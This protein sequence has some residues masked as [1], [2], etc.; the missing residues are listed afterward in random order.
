MLVLS[1]PLEADFATYIYIYSTHNI[2]AFFNNTN[3][4]AQ[5]IVYY[6]TYNV[7]TKQ[8]LSLQ[9]NFDFNLLN[10]LVVQTIETNSGKNQRN[11][12]CATVCCESKK[13]HSEQ[14]C[15]L[16]YKIFK[17]VGSSCIFFSRCFIID[18]VSLLYI[19]RLF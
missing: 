19:M 5:R 14:L 6:V 13:F 3:L 16:Q 17:F 8:F 11:S 18:A 7:A 15:S 1:P 9:F 10:M 2:Y 12:S 4:I